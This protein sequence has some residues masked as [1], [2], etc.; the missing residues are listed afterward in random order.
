VRHPDRYGVVVLAALI[1]SALIVCNIRRGTTGRRLLAVRSNERG[2]AAAGVDVY[3]VKVYSFVIA[4]ALAA[5]AG[6]L[7]SF[8]NTNVIASSFS[9]FPSITVVAM[10]VVGGV[11][12]VGGAIFGATLLQGGV[13]AELLRDFSEIDRYLPLAGGILLLYTLRSEPS[14]L[15]LMNLRLAKRAVRPILAPFAHRAS[16]HGPDDHRLSAGMDDTLETV[17]AKTLIAENVTVAFG[18]AVALR[19]V[20]IDVRPGELHGLIGSNGAGKTTLIDVVSGFVAP[21]SGRVAL[22]DVVITGWSPQRRARA[23]LTR[24]FQSLE[25]F[26]DL[27]VA[28]NLAVA[29][30]PGRWAKYLT[31][32]IRPD[33]SVLDRSTSRALRLFGLESVADSAP[34]SLAFGQRRMVAVARSIAA[35]PSI[36]LLDEP[37]SG[38]DDSETAE[39]GRTLA[40]FVRSTGTGVLLVEHNVDLVMS[41]CDRVTVM[42]AGSVVASGDPAAISQDPGFLCDYIGREP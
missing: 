39:L 40:A 23:G 31:D 36:L 20:S 14:G 17:Q 18:G 2:A 28:E 21:Q 1:G 42:S 27:T 6:V 32:P 12:S 5:A 26:N 33:R 25:L 34:E 30:D 29:T 41:I 9:V 24:S 22:D 4:S 3:S 10:T 37:T 15:F 7:S 8:R 19:N 38:L 16:A 35:Q 11:G 13:G